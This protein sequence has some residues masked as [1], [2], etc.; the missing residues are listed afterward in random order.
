MLFQLSYAGS[1]GYTELWRASSREPLAPSERVNLD[2]LL[3]SKSVF[4][5]FMFQCLMPIFKKYL[6]DQYKHWNAIKQV[7]NMNSYTLIILFNFLKKSF[8]ILLKTLF[9]TIVMV[10]V[11][12]VKPLNSCIFYLTFLYFPLS[13]IDLNKTVIFFKQLCQTWLLTG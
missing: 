2:I 1:K 3:T 13:W 4:I 11:L 9:R 12:C 5:F 6:K 7:F 8:S 10:L